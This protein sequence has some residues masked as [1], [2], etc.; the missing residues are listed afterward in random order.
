MAECLAIGGADRRRLVLGEAAELEADTHELAGRDSFPRHCTTPPR[1][2]KQSIA[3]R[4]P[5]PQIKPGFKRLKRLEAVDHVGI[6]VGSGF[7]ANAG[8]QALVDAIE[9]L[10]GARAARFQAFAG[11][12]DIVDI[13]ARAQK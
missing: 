7:E 3:A 4:V 6:G 13:T 2:V 1:I 9:H 5:Q 11:V 10:F 12:E 8:V